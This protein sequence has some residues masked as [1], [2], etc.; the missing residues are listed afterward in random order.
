MTAGFI[1]V[2]SPNQFTAQGTY[3]RRGGNKLSGTCIVH[4]SEGDW[5]RGVQALTDL[6]RTRRDYGSYHAGCDWADIAW[7]YPWEWEAWQDSETNNWAVGISAACKT[8]D[9]ATMPPEIAE[10]FYRNMAKMGASFIRYM[11]AKGINVPTRRITGWEARNRVPGFCAHGDSGIARSDPGRDFDW[12]RFFQYIN[13]EL[14]RI[15]TPPPAPAPPAPAPPPPAPAPEKQ[16]IIRSDQELHWIVDPG[17]TLTKVALHYYGDAKYVNKI[18]AYNNIDPN[19]IRVGQKIWVPGPIRWT[20][21]G[22]D[23]VQSICAYYGI[24]WEW[25][26]RY[27]PGQ[28]RGPNSELYIGNVLTIIP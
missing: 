9:W 21:E 8:T 27:N 26:A 6:L 25:L 5:R 28:V 20:I 23:T 15:P 24:S 7:Y 11:A 3:P 17:D 2:D 12:N 18:A 10:G 14:G 4:T 13:E 16:Q 1:L 19:K 22:P